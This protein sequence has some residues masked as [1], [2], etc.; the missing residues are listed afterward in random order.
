[1]HKIT[2]GAVE[3][4]ERGLLPPVDLLPVVPVRL[5]LAPHGALA[6]VGYAGGVDAVARSALGE[7]Q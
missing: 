4:T 3:V 6:E 1:M 7:E 2:S 5:L